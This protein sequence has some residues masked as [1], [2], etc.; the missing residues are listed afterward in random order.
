MENYSE[1]YPLRITAQMYKH[2]RKAAE[3]E[4]LTIA[5]YLRKLIREAMAKE[6]P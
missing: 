2:V 4:H 3:A 6:K 1:V 5:Q